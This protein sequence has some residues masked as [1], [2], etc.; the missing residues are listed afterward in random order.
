MF[1]TR[2]KVLRDSSAMLMGAIASPSLARFLPTPP[3]PPDIYALGVRVFFVGTWLLTWDPKY[4]TSRLL[5][6][7]ADASLGHKFPYGPWL[8]G[9]KFDNN[10]TDLKENHAAAHADRNSYDVTVTGATGAA[11][12]KDLFSAAARDCDFN[13]I[14]ETPPLTF[15]TGDIR[16][17][18][19]PFPTRLFVAGIVPGGTITTD[20][21]H[22]LEGGALSGQAA[23]AHVLEYAGAS[24]S[25]TFD[26][27]TVNATKNYTSDFHF[28]TVP[29]NPTYHGP[30]MFGY[31]IQN[32]V[33]NGYNVQLN[34]LEPNIPPI[35]GGCISTQAQGFDIGE[36]DYFGNQGT[37]KAK[38]EA[39][40][41]AQA[42]PKPG[43]IVT[44][45]TH[46]TASCAGGGIG[47]GGGG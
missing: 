18:S 2:R 33:G 29:T 26:G 39:K 15:T 13:Y 5:A 14:P 10:G 38:P 25:L 23:M 44:I 8:A 40:G 37:E 11:S 36:L 4:P 46:T 34:A 28:H 47:V 19:L 27:T 22:P 31:L 42:A 35:L 43:E 1:Y 17:I 6:I 41:H 9:G 30:K 12:L 32:I 20:N 7:T 24:A 16:V 21:Q 3:P 45:F